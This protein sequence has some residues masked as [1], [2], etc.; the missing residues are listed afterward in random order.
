MYSPIFA[1]IKLVQDFASQQYSC[2]L[3]CFSACIRASSKNI[4]INKIQPQSFSFQ[5]LILK[6]RW[7]R[8]LSP[9]TAKCCSASFPNVSA[10]VES[11]SPGL[12]RSLCPSHLG[13]YHKVATGTCKRYQKIKCFNLSLNGTW[14][15][16]FCLCYGQGTFM[17]SMQRA[18]SKDPTEST[19]YIHI[20]H[21]TT[22]IVHQFRPSRPEWPKFLVRS[23]QESCTVF[24]YLPSN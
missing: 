7:Q 16:S 10:K 12:N 18:K 22:H 20:P 8:H 14:F 3:G 1:L 13:W 9:Y 4:Q 24:P 19:M 6:G 21:S 5:F 11:P 17:G 15:A 2:F 23:R